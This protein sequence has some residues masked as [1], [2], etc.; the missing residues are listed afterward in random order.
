MEDDEIKY[1]EKIAE[2]EKE[3]SNKESFIQELQNTIW[4]LQTNEEKLT[5]KK[6]FKIRELEEEN[7]MNR[8]VIENLNMQ[9]NELTNCNET[10]RLELK[11]VN[12]IN[13]N[14]NNNTDVK[15]KDEKNMKNDLKG[16]HWQCRI[17]ELEEKCILNETIIQ[18][19]N[20]ELKNA[21]EKYDEMKGDHWIRARDLYQ[22]V[23][24]IFEYEI[25]VAME[26]ADT[27]A[28]EEVR[29][30]FNDFGGE[31]VSMQKDGYLLFERTEKERKEE[32]VKWNVQ[33]LKLM[34]KWN[35][36]EENYRG[37]MLDTEDLKGSYCL[38]DDPLE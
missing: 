38:P 19:L 18:N 24:K 28:N 1:K 6:E 22:R 12:I 21:N 4:N 36:V 9:V 32:A 16:N 23:D 15:L 11:D 37:K 10:L 31:L 34:K 14:V 2:L 7:M 29:E 30:Y 25:H 26:Y 8:N 5:K 20:E 27:S 3:V 33:C 17:N 35:I 13:E